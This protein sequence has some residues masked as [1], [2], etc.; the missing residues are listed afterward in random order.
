MLSTS[1]AVPTQGATPSKLFLLGLLAAVFAVNVIDVFAP[2]LYPEIAATFRVTVGTATQLSAFSSIAGVI[3]GLALSAF[4]LRFR[5]KT[6]LT[7]GVFAVVICVIGV[8]LAPNFLFAQIFYALNGV[9]SVMVAVMASTLIGELY[10]MEKKA[11]RISLILSVTTFASV[12][13]NPITGWIANAGGITSW[14]STLLWFMIPVTFTSL[15]LVVFLVPNKPRSMQLSVNK[16]PF[17]NGY[18]N[19]LTNKSA[20]ACLANGFMAWFFFATNIF[21]SAFLRDVFGVPPFLRSL[22]PLLGGSLLI[23]GMFTGGFLVNSVGRK[24]LAIYTAVPATIF[25]VIGYPLSI[26]IPNIWIVVCTRLLAGF[27]GGMPMVAGANLILEQVPKF[28]GTLM[29]LSS[30]MAGLGAASGV[31]VAGRI[32]NI[33]NDPVIGYPVAMVTLGIGGLVGVVILV[34]FAKDPVKNKPP[35]TASSQK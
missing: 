16:E 12:I 18:K 8:F 9:G 27:I 5:Y 1:P 28:R 24:R 33:I 35:E 29:S 23:A 19:I 21:A 11:K 22:L 3:T 20:V 7:T 4:S 2:L 31:L 13:G 14:R 6:L 26:I 10:P 17:M 32:L 30:V 15:M 25:A 34:F